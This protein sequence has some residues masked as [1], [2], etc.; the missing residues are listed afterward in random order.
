MGE[1]IIMVMG[2]IIGDIVG[3]TYERGR[4]CPNHMKSKEFDFFKKW[5][6]GKEVR[7]TDDTVLTVAVADALMSDGDFKSAI[8]R[9]SNKYPNSG[10]GGRFREWMTDKD[11]QP[12]GSFGNGS[13]MRV[14]PVAW[15]YDNIHDVMDV[16]L[17]T[18]EVTH[19]HPDGING[20]QAVAAAIFLART[21]ST[22][23]EIKAFV[24]KGCSYN[25]SRTL[26]GIRPGYLFDSSCGGSVPEAII[27]FLE[28]VDFEDSIRN[29]ISLGGDTDTQAAIAGSIA[30][31][32]YGIPDFLKKKAIPFLPNA[33]FDI[34]MK[35][36]V[37]Y[38][39]PKM[40]I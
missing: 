19:N 39:S 31:A 2:A 25:L 30:E 23:E 36:D 32:Y 17:K 14:S 26:N 11:P 29:A 5:E 20:A 7:F 34:V 21:G 1:G 10:F 6:H 22:K 35:F 33:I 37:K 3:S 4:K 16:A 28:S 24:E 13:A 15:F 9:Y 40:K 12:Y 27:A 8:L 18:A 38:V